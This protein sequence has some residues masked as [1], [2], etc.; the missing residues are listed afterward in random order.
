MTQSSPVTEYI[1]KTVADWENFTP[2]ELPPLAEQID[3]ETYQQLASYESE[4]TEP[5]T[6]EYLW[7]NVTVL[8]DGEVFVTP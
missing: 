1:V 3:T 7:Y 2:E 6:F 8:P 4:L 5:L